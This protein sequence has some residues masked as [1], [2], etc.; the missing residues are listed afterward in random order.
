[1]K[2]II[3]AGGSGFVGQALAPLL[4]EKGYE[5]IVLGRDAAHRKDG[6][7][8]QQWNGKTIGGW[9][10]AIEGAEAIVNLTGKNIN[11]R[12]T[13]ENRRVILPFM[14]AIGAL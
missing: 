3:L 1:M 2:R 9:A 4:L 12:H 14:R 6:I 5:V 7:D 11:C 10:S 13:A 8:H